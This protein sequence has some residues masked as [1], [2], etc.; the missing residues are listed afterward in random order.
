MNKLQQRIILQYKELYPQDTLKEIS[1]KTNIQITRVFRLFNGSE[2]KLKEY[3][4]FETA[5]DE[6]INNNDF[7]HKAKE[8]SLILSPQKLKDIYA[9]MNQSIKLKTL[10]ITSTPTSINFQ[11]QSTIVA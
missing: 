10:Q 7:Y 9:L 6:K 2:M 8:C 11:L 5:I 3:E 1:L 4:S